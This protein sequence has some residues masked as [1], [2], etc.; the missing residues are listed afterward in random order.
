[1]T[2]LAPTDRALTP[3]PSCGAQND[4][5]A[6]TC[7]DCGT[8]LAATAATTDDNPE[9]ELDEAL[10][11]AAASGFDVDMT[12][13]E[14]SVTCPVCSTSFALAE[15]DDVHGQ[16]VRDTIRAGDDL[17][18]VTLAC[19]S[20]GAAGRLY[21]DAAEVEPA[22][23]PAT[24]GGDAR[25]DEVE[26]IHDRVPGSTEDHP[27]GADR[28]FFEPAEPG[29]LEDQGPLLDED[30]EDIR[31]YTGEPVETLEGWVLPQQQNA[32]PGNIAG[33]GEFPD[34]TTPPA[35]GRD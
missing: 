10:R 24:T 8:S 32:G 12:L 30:G 18:V 16:A 9:I 28:Q 35:Q 2:D 31:Q 6:T 4:P 29:S 15:G 21:G 25:P 13:A 3:C 1:M 14:G 7:E 19:P 17:R 11:A 26:P 5:D 33:G 27:L 20:C 23:H 34:P 22:L